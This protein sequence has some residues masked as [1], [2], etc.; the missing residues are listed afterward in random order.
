MVIDCQPLDVLLLSVTVNNCQVGKPSSWLAEHHWFYPCALTL[1]SGVYM[2]S[3]ST[4]NKWKSSYDPECVL[5]DW[6]HN[7]PINYQWKFTT[8]L[9][10]VPTYNTFMTVAFFNYNCYSPLCFAANIEKT[11]VHGYQGHVQ[12][13][14]WCNHCYKQVTSQLTYYCYF[15]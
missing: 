8:T 5:R 11:D 15:I 6:K 9:I 7:Q 14:Q 12:D 2:G 10:T 3:H 4:S 1:Y 13:C